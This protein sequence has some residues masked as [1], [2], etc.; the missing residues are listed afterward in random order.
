MEAWYSSRLL[1]RCEV[2]DADEPIYEESIR[3]VHARNELDALT[4]SKRIGK[5][6]EDRYKDCAGGM[7]K[8]RFV[9]VLEVQDLH[10]SSLQDHMEVYS[11]LLHPGEAVYLDEEIVP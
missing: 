1:F 9:K 5:G 3:I 4:R 2:V 10:E 6:E 7:L 11:R 8:W